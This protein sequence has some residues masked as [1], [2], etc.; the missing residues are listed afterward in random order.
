MKEIRKKEEVE[1]FLKQFLPKLDIWG[2]IYIDRVKNDAA[3]RAMGITPNARETVIRSIEADDYVETITDIFSWG[4]MWVFGKD[5]FDKEIYIKI[6]LG[7]PN[8][9]TI[10]ISFHESEHEINYAFKNKEGGK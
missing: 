5:A 10:C 9:K 4:D 6:T 3:L 1:R 2:I 7:Q 8:S